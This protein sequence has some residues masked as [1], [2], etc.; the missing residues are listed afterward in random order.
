LTEVKVK[1]TKIK[2]RLEFLRE[3]YGESILKQVINGM[4]AEDQQALEIVLETDWYPIEL[5][6]HLIVRICDIAAEGDLSIYNRMGCYAAQKALTTIYKAWGRSKDPWK[7]LGNMVDLHSQVNDPGEMQIIA[8]GVNHAIIKV[9]QP[10]STQFHC[11]A[12]RAFYE[13]A[14]KLCNLTAVSVK[15]LGCTATGNS[16][17]EFEVKWK[18]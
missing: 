6:N 4:V 12:A 18:T 9:L 17:C 10:P 2:G 8:Q 13:E 14:M 7:M 15:K 1:G 16:Y 11:L 5:Y 3:T